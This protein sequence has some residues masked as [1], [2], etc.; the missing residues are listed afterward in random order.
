MKV[1]SKH[2]ISSNIR[3]LFAAIKSDL[4]DRHLN[5][6]RKGLC[7]IQTSSA[8]EYKD[9][10]VVIKHDKADM[11][12]GNSILQLLDEF[13]LKFVEK[14]G[15]LNK[16][17][18]KR[19]EML[20]MQ[21]HSIKKMIDNGPEKYRAVNL[22][23]IDYHHLETTWIPLVKQRK[24]GEGYVVCH[25][26]LNSKDNKLKFLVFQMV[27]TSPAL[28]YKV[29]N[30]T[31]R[32]VAGFWVDGHGNVL[33][34]DLND[35]GK[36]RLSLR[37]WAKYVDNT[38]LKPYL[39]R[40]I[41]IIPTHEYLSTLPILNYP[42]KNTDRNSISNLRDLLENFTG[43]KCSRRCAQLHPIIAWNFLKTSRCI[44]D[45]DLSK[46]FQFVIEH[47]DHQALAHSLHLKYVLHSLYGSS[48]D[49]ICSGVLFYYY[50]EKIGNGQIEIEGYNLISE[51]R[52]YIEQKLYNRVYP[53]LK[54]RSVKRL[55][56]ENRKSREDYYQA[57]NP[58]DI[59]FD[60]SYN[61]LTSNSSYKYKYICSQ[62]TLYQVG[63]RLH[64]CIIFYLE[65]IANGECGFYLI[66]DQETNKK[67]VVELVKS[68]TRI[69]ISELKGKFNSPAPDS[70][71]ANI[72]KQLGV[73]ENLSRVS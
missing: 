61:V 52:D 47:S 13:K 65:K 48:D 11:S 36:R 42:F 17:S 33:V 63:K 38:F 71:K 53:N 14:E 59:T 6:K 56:A 70:L 60:P 21:F 25:C 4:R 20:P 55:V 69:V 27:K 29:E 66:T 31:T 26:Q 50:L 35:S 32:L 9:I 39:S 73:N 54:I 41:S 30:C 72:Q 45:S 40:L 8:K 10:K 34:Y 49:Y 51:I 18:T 5:Y 68:E 37:N 15:G 64:L 43:T 67:Y 16:M 58:R 2:S 19:S 28:K 62:E 23:L 44:K 7:E 12:V 46:L 24:Y 3:N 1:T 57:I 22:E